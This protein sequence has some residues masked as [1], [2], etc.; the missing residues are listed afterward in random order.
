MYAQCVSVVRACVLLQ[1]DWF[2]ASGQWP[3]KEEETERESVSVKD[4]ERER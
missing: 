3:T 1:W 4:R 2:N